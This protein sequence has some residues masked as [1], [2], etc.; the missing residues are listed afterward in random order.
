[1]AVWVAIIVALG[2][3]FLLPVY[4]PHTYC[5]PPP[6][7]QACMEAVTPVE[8]ISCVLTGFGTYVPSSASGPP[9][10]ANYRLGCYHSPTKPQ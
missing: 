7:G 9:V 8:S 4:F 10:A 2:I 3:F 1:M 6:P 5:N